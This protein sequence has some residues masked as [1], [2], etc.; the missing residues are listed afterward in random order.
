M[1]QLP[2]EPGA[3]AD[4]E[5]NFYSAIVHQE[6]EMKLQA[7][8]IQDITP[9]ETIRQPNSGDIASLSESL[10]ESGQMVPIMVRRV[11]DK[12]ETIFGNRRV[13]RLRTLEGR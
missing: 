13:A 4:S 1:S 2:Q 10:V 7:I 11:G 8:K 6:D 3:F 5:K 12:Y 9:G